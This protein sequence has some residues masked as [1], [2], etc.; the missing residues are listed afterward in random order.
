MGVDGCVQ[1]VKCKVCSKVEHKNKLL[2]PKWDSLQKHAD[3]K[4]AEKNMKGM[5][6]GEWYTS[7]DCKHNKNVTTYACKGRESVLQQVTIGLVSE[8][9]KKLVQFATLFHTLK[10]GRPMLKYEAHKE[11]FDFLNFEKNPKMH[12]TYSLGW[13]MAQ[14]MHGIVLEATKSIIGTTQFIS[15]MMRLVPSTIKGSF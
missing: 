6:K 14:H 2:A 13:A 12:W 8:K 10:H 3:W 7:N 4:K 5:K 1:F 9:H 15:F 11:L